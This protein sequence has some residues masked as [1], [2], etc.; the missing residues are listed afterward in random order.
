MEARAELRQVRISP[1]KVGIVLDLIR[2]KPCEVAMAILK[3]TPKAACEPLEKLLKSA[4]ANAENNHNMDLSR[5]YVAEAHCGAGVTLKR[6][7]PAAK[8]SA[9]RILKRTSNIVLVVK[10]SE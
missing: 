2:N 10:E 8:G 5:C 7:R 1:R 6:N 3:N 9:H 4:M